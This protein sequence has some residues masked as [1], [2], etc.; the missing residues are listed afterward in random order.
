MATSFVCL[1]TTLEP[2]SKRRRLVKQGK[3][4]IT[5][6]ISLGGCVGYARKISD[7]RTKRSNWY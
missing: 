6:G 3:A 2:K 7:T 4:L 1:A 5:E